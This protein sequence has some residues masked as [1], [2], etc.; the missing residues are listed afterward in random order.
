MQPAMF[1]LEIETA[2]W[3]RGRGGG[4]GKGEGGALEKAKSNIHSATHN[5]LL[6]CDRHSPPWHKL[7]SLLS[8]PLPLKSKMAAI[9]ATEDIK[10]SLAKIT[11]AL[12]A[13]NK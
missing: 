11:P 7:F 6:I 1:D 4:P 13:I 3:R 5:P 9:L 8:L 10:H 12:K 2:G